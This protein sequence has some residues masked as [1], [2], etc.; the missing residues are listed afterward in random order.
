LRVARMVQTGD[1]HPADA[2]GIQRQFDLYPT[3]EASIINIGY[4]TPL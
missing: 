4:S 3:L 2:I 1:S